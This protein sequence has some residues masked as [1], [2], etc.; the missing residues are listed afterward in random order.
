ME[1]TNIP[2]LRGNE[3]HEMQKHCHRFL[4]SNV[5]RR[6]PQHSV[7]WIL[8]DFLVD[9]LADC[10]L[11][12]S[13]VSISGI[14]QCHGSTKNT[15]DLELLLRCYF[16]HFYREASQLQSYTTQIHTLIRL[17][18]GLRGVISMQLSL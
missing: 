1:Q 3:T 5:V 8:S 17:K 10:Q 14:L 15:N 6:V 18:E 16:R 9:L 13:S 4:L 11:V 12:C 7:S 2:L